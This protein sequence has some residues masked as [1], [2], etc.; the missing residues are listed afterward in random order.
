MVIKSKGVEYNKLSMTILY[1]NE[2]VK[3]QFCSDYKKFWRYPEQVKKSLSPLKT[4]LKI[5]LP[6]RI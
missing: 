4:L 1:K 3:K 6:Y 2:T 5:L